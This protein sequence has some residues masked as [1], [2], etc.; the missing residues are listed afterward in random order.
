VAGVCDHFSGSIK[1]WEISWQIKLVYVSKD[2]SLLSFRVIKMSSRN[3][4]NVSWSEMVTRLLSFGL[5]SRPSSVL[6]PEKGYSVRLHKCSAV[7][8]F[9]RSPRARVLR[10]YDPWRKGGPAIIKPPD[11]GLPVGPR[12][13]IWYS[14]R[15]NIS[16]GIRQPEDAPDG[17]SGSPPGMEYWA[18]TGHGASTMKMIMRFLRRTLL[19]GVT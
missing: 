9:A 8:D 15:P 17:V 6:T 18:G 7:E 3:A 2:S 11:T 1:R 4:S 19:H 10:I 16:A 14:D 5:P 13:L 12:I